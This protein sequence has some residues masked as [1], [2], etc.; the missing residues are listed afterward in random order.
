MT[1]LAW[2]LTRLGGRRAL[3]STGLTAF[4]VAATALLLQFVVACNFAFVER[5]DRTEWRE[6]PAAEGGSAILASAIDYYGDDQI[7]RID[8]ARLDDDAPAPPGLD[9]FPA[10]GEVWV[11]PALAELLEGV[12]DEDF[13]ARYD[14]AIAGTVGAEALAHEGELLAVVGREADDPAMTTERSDGDMV[15]PRTIDGFSGGEASMVYGVYRPAAIVATVLMAVPVAVFGAAAARLTVARRDERLAALRLI[16]ATPAQVVR[17]T[18]IETVLAAVAGTIAGT[19]LWMASTPLFARI[20]IDGGPWYVADLWGGAAWMPVVAAAVPLM[21][22]VSAVVGLRGVVI[23]PLGVARRVRRKG[24]GAIRLAVFAAVAV[25]FLTLSQLLGSGDM[26]FTAVLL[27][28]FGA[29]IAALNL[30]GPWAVQQIGKILA[31]TARGP[32]RMLAARRLLDDPKAAWR[33]VAGVALAGFIAG[34]IALVP[35]GQPELETT[36]TETL[37]AVVDSGHA[38]ELASRAEAALDGLAEVELHERTDRFDESE[39]VAVVTATTP[40]GEL[41]HVRSILTATLAGDPPQRATDQTILSNQIMASVRVGAIV[42]LAVVFATA[43]LSAGISSIGS[44]LDRRKTYRLL[45]LSGTPQRVLDAAR[46][47]ETLL[48]LAVIGGASVLAGMALNAPLIGS[49]GLQDASGALILGVT[50]AIGTAAV[51]GAGALSRPLLRATMN[52][53]SPRPD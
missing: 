7:T 13:L 6:P 29:M 4:A 23:S 31:G 53:V 15:S 26:I 40:T 34:S 44:V 2:R 32:A 45:H 41:E 5:A 10:P 38:E 33:G 50:L 30:T 11:S 46:R 39:T 17:L 37:S 19:L 21:V 1:A 36:A 28:L 8:L 22:A 35:M 51:I 42:V 18:L 27:V 47:Q 49:Q 12:P 48:P 16:G 14:G 24:L 3:L 25:A 20:P 52:D 9:A 43:A